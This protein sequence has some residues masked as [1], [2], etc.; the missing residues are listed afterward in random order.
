MKEKVEV[1][2]SEE[3]ISK[4]ILEIAGRINADYKGKDLILICV[5]KGGVMFMCEHAK[6]HDFKVRHDLMSV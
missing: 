4:R 1:L 2:I 5:L 3:E 6:R